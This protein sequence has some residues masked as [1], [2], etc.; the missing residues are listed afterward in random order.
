MALAL[1]MADETSSSPVPFF[2]LVQLMSVHQC[3]G[4]TL[5]KSPDS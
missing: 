2:I 5:F 4:T 3:F 1:A